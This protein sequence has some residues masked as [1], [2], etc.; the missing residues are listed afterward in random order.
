MTFMEW[1]Q[2]LIDFIM[3]LVAALKKSDDTVGDGETEKDKKTY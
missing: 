2:T 1:L 3:K